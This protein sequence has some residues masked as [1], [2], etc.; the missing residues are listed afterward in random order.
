MCLGL[1]A[2]EPGA[3]PPPPR[4]GSPASYVRLVAFTVAVIALAWILALA[5]TAFAIRTVLVLCFAMLTGRARRIDVPAAASNAAD[6]RPPN[7]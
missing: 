4:S 2:L 3:R 5:G 1:L 6:A 7:Y